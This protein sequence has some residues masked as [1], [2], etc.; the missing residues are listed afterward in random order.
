MKLLIR[1]CHVAVVLLCTAV[2]CIGQSVPSNFSEWLNQLVQ[3]ALDKAKV[4][5]NGKGSS[6][7]KETPSGDDRSVSLVDQ[8]SSTDFL[9]TAVQLVPVSN[10]SGLAAGQ[11]TGSMADAS[12][13]GSGSGSVTV[14][15]YSLLAALSKRSLTDPT[16]YK[17]H[18]N[19]R[20]VSFTL[21]TAASD[22][23]TDGTSKVGTIV[24]LKLAVINGRD[25]YSTTGRMAATEVQRANTARTQ[26]ANALFDRMQRLIFEACQPDGH[27]ELGKPP[28]DQVLYV[29]AFTNFWIRFNDH[30]NDLMLSAALLKEID[31][32]VQQALPGYESYQKLVQ[33]VYDKVRNGR[34]L[35]ISY[36]V[37]KRPDNGNND[38]RAEASFDYGL[39]D[40]ITWTWNASFDYKDRK[41][42]PDS[43]GGRIATEFK[44]NVTPES[45]I[46]LGRAPVTLSF[47]GEAKWMEMTKPQYT[48]QAKLSIPLGT[49]LDL[50]I[51]YRFA[52]RRVQIGQNDSEAR[53]GLTVDVGRLVQLLK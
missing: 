19:A 25:L 10:I 51:A 14:T 5:E 13:Q 23:A 11:Q 40:R 9:S 48:F 43:R 36:Q 39:T 37:V 31:S 7:Q 45:L 18:T 32:L 4:L 44:G 50:P 24:G 52:N 12:R 6:R 16:F 53:L 2:P 47:S 29:A 3:A 42:L 41:Q 26:I 17:E 20:R 28:I 1:T 38:H 34:Q 21:G 49:G 8:S 22:V 33:E 15:G 27:C 46:P 30:M 35:A